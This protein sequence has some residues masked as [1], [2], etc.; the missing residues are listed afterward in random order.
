MSIY[1][2]P[3]R[4][5]RLRK[6]MTVRNMM[7]ENWLSKHNLIAPLFI[8]H[9][10]QKKKP[11][12]T[13]PGQFQLS[14]HDL[15]QEIEEIL[16]LGIP[17]VLL[18]GIPSDKDAT[19]S[20]SLN[21]TGVIQE[22]IRR[23]KQI[24]KDLLVIADV[25]LCE[26]TD[27]GH[28]G[29]FE[30]ESLDNDLTLNQLVSQA[31]SFAESGADWVAPSSNTDGMVG[32]IRQGLDENGFQNVAILSYAVKYSSSFYGPFRE[33]AEGAPKF[34]DRKTYQMNPANGQEAIREAA[35]DLAE[36]ADILMVKPAMNYLDV[37]YRIKQ[38]FPDVP[39]CAYQISGEYSMIKAAAAQGWLHEEEAIFES[40]LAIK[41]AGSDLVITY[42]AKDVA[43]IL[44][45]S[46]LSKP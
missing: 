27:H 46:T 21:H 32:A 41:R 33:A 5:R 34:G 10:L 19:G 39:L 42:F 23:I 6:N 29:V 14:L 1:H 16:R 13:M 45:R 20:A 9:K 43:R 37:I 4:M 7:Q 40:L 2:L 30:K 24:N 3:L 8:N 15:D 18:F 44:N 35:L 22:A 25:C 12:S 36:G 28:C 17:A 38:K 11:I 26:Y 31:I